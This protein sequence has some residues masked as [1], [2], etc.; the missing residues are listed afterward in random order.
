MTE[1]KLQYMLTIE[2]LGV[3]SPAP[4]EPSAVP[5]GWAEEP[6]TL[7][8]MTPAGKDDN[9]NL[10]VVVLWSRSLNKEEHIDF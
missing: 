1:T 5:A 3:L 2:V 4:T 7:M 6:W 9:G 10:G 8:S